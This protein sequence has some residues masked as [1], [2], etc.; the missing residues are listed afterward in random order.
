[1]NK[2][3]SADI[4]QNLTLNGETTLKLRGAMYDVWTNYFPQDKD[5]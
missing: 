1:M 3:K 5:Q 2:K 4:I